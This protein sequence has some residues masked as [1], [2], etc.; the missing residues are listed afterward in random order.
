MKRCFVISPIGPEGSGIRQHADDVYDFIVKP[1]MA[2]CGIQ[3]LRS[4]HMLE[5]GK[6]T[7]QMFRKLMSDMCLAVITSQHNPNV[8][9][10]LA[11]AQAAARPVIILVEKGTELPFDV[12]HLRCVEYDLQLRPVMEGVYQE[13]I[14]AHVRSFEEREWVVEP[15]F[16][17]ASPL[18]LEGGVGS[19][20]RFFEKAS[21]HTGVD[22][23][24]RSVEHTER[25]FAMLN[26]VPFGWRCTSATRKLYLAKAQA[27]CRIRFLTIHPDNPVL[28][29]LFPPRASAVQFRRARAELEE[30]TEFL[31]ELAE[32]SDHIEYRQLRSGT[33]FCEITKLDDHATYLPY[34]N[35]QELNFLPLWEV[36]RRHP[37]Y[38]ILEQEFEHL[39]DACVDAEQTTM[40]STDSRADP[41]GAHEALPD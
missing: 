39:W 4:D 13:Q 15:P 28:P 29:M 2:E 26:A 3:A 20:L 24:V 12:E 25:S 1:A 5:P 6:I 23:W 32:A 14:V 35:T 8:Y 22:A 19:G 7:D 21:D 27:G 18:S 9:Y 34:L 11:I 10:E 37:L 31:S 41:L 30:I 17:A 38:R 36:Q 33:P 40:L 16:G